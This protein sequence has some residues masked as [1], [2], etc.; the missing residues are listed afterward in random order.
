VKHTIGHFDVPGH[1]VERPLDVITLG[2]LVLEQVILLE[3]LPTKGGQEVVPVSKMVYTAGG[4][5]MNVATFIGRYGGMSAVL[6]AIGKGRYAE[7]VWDELSKSNVETHLLRV[8]AQSE[9]SLIVILS[10]TNGDWAVLDHMDPKLR[11]GRSD[12]PS[13]EQFE[14]AKLLH[15]DG[16]S[17]LTGGDEESVELAIARAKEAGC[18]LSVD[19]SV[20]GASEKP[21]YLA[22][23]FQ[24]ADIVFA[25][26][27]EALQVTGAECV[28]QAADT[29]RAWQIPVGIIKRGAEGSVVVLAE[30]LEQIPSFPVEVV[31]TVAAGDAYI[32]T[33]LHLLLDG[34]DL[35]KAATW[36]SAAGALACLG[37]GSLSSRF[38]LADVE[39]LVALGKRRRSNNNSS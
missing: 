11:I 37:L 8:S 31:D 12:I 7:P 33:T 19:G 20:P 3:Q 34:K 18:L 36:G 21:D 26:E 10:Q 25:N 14:K 24:R 32:A 15:V 35:I 2:S 29:F 27:Y 38:T 1:L 28:D 5:A 39:A 9:G 16:F 6:S 17:F 22:R 13:T 23:L 30:G 4:C